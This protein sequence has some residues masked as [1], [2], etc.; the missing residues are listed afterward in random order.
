MTNVERY[1]MSLNSFEEAVQDALKLEDPTVP[2][3]WDVK[4]QVESFGFV[5]RPQYKAHLERVI[6]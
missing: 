6:D 2:G 4:L 3:N 1:G 5:G